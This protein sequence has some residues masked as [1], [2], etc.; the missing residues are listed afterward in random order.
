MAWCFR[1]Q[2]STWANFDPVLC[3]HMV[4]LANNSSMRKLVSTNIWH[5][6]FILILGSIFLIRIYSSQC[7]TIYTQHRKASPDYM[8]LKIIQITLERVSFILKAR[9]RESPLMSWRKTRKT[10]SIRPLTHWYRVTQHISVGTLIIIGSDNGLSP[11]RSE[12]IIW[13]NAGI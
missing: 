4:S 6:W 2:G 3:R 1:R 9:M 11:G 7:D 8:H 12:V 10:S 13:T 5:K